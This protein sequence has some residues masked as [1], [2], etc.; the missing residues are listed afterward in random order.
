M[1]TTVFKHDCA[2]CEL[3][4]RQLA[5]FLRLSESLSKDKND[6]IA[7]EPVK[8]QSGSPSQSEAPHQTGPSTTTTSIEEGF[9]AMLERTKKLKEEGDEYFANTFETKIP[10]VLSLMTPK[11][12]AMSSFP[13]FETLRGLFFS[14]WLEVYTGYRITGKLYSQAAEQTTLRT[15]EI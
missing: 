13:R 10:D 5:E 6:S 2:G 7:F 1:T 8:Q 3:G 14:C 9:N 4:R 15:L 11:I 12:K